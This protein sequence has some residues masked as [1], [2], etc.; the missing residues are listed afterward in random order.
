MKSL[1]KKK[2]YHLMDVIEK[3]TDLFLDIVKDVYNQYNKYNHK[4]TWTT[5]E[6]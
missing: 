3:K 6:K 2:Y 5:I 4:M 1:G